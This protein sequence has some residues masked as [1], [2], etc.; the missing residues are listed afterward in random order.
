MVSGIL[1]LP[2]HHAEIGLKI[3]SVNFALHVI[4]AKFGNCLYIDTPSAFSHELHPIKNYYRDQL[5]LSYT[6][7]VVLTSIFRQALCPK[8][9]LKLKTSKKNILMQSYPVVFQ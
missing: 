9:I 8:E 7:I 4:S 5:H 6:G 3:R 1:P 2:R